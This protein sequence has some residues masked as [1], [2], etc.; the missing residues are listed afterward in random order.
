MPLYDFQC[1]NEECKN[2]FESL[3][4]VGTEVKP[5]PKCT[6]PAERKTSAGQRFHFNWFGDMY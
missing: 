6:K 5:C 1:T 3:V 4:P 2:K